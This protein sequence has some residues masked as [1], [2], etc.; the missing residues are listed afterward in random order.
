MTIFYSIQIPFQY[1]IGIKIDLAHHGRLLWTLDNRVESWL[2]A[3]TVGSYKITSGAD[4][5]NIL[6]CLHD[7]HYDL[8][9]VDELLK[10]FNPEVSFTSNS[11]AIMFKLVWV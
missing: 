5:L 2:E 10:R 1:V 3:N 8:V 9:S 7:T 11:D 6:N 4:G